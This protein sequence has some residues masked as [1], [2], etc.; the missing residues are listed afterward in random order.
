MINP[1]SVWFDKLHVGDVHVDQDGSLRFIYTDA[2]ISTRGAFAV[3]NT[4]PLTQSEHAS[5]K[6]SPWL[7]NLLPEEEQL[8]VL[9]RS[10]GIDR[11][12]TLALLKEIGG[13]T[14]GALSFGEPSLSDEWAYTPLSEFYETS[15][16]RVAL[17]RHFDDLQQRPFLAG[18]EGIR[19]SLAGGQKK[20]ALAVINS[21]GDPVLRLPEHG[22]QLAIPKNGAPS[23]IILKPDNPLLRGI[24]ENETYC[25]K[26]ANA[27]GIKSAEATIIG[28]DNQRAIAVLRYDRRLNLKGALQR[29]HQ[30]DFAQANAIPPGRKYERGTLAGPGLDEIIR[31]GDTLSPADSLALFDQLIF[32]ILVANTDAHAKNYSIL[33]PVSGVPK[34]APL[35][36]V[37]CVLAWPRVVQYFAQNIAGKKRKPGDVAGRH[38][39]AIAKSI[40]YRPT[41]VRNR[42]QELVDLMVAKRVEVTQSLI[43]LDASVEGYVGETA[44]LIEE[45]ALRIAGRLKEDV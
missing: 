18:E 31:T 23:T 8:S 38:W 29:I 7:A 32:N 11:S 26:L 43:N 39:T 17:Q 12:D 4:L 35:Y 6:I 15:D 25:L 9:T 16:E 5:D 28:A 3:S 14:A 1:V 40:G 10:L 20:T 24:V 37:S 41:D 30:E 21:D 27:I 34:L 45:N 22:D 19:L 42:V 13:D 2:W 44:R 33:L 36:D